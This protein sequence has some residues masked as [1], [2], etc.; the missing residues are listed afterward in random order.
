MSIDCITVTISKGKT[1][2]EYDF[3]GLCADQIEKLEKR[4]SS[5][6]KAFTKDYAIA[7]HIINNKHANDNEGIIKIAIDD[8]F[9]DVANKASIFYT[10]CMNKIQR[11]LL[12]N[13]K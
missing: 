4:L 1:I 7:L 8:I 6:K 11:L 12:E 10:E 5:L 2:M 9:N 13:I 3:S